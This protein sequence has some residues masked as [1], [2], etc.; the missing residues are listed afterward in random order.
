MT[1]SPFFEDAVEYYQHQ[2]EASVVQ[3]LKKSVAESVGVFG[4][5]SF[6]G[7]GCDP[8]CVRRADIERHDLGFSERPRGCA[9]GC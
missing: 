1:G 3:A 6:A 8:D 4:G 9:Q 2:E 7:K 5:G